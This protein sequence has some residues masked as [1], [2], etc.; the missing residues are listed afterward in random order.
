[1]LKDV[2]AG[3]VG[4]DEESKR[5]REVETIY[6]SDLKKLQRIREALA[7]KNQVNIFIIQ[8]KLYT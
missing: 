8:H 2:E 5:M 6:E 3:E 1:M 7:L 4:D